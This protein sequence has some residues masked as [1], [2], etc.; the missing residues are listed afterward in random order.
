MS[1]SSSDYS[2]ESSIESNN[3][4]DRDEIVR[5]VSDFYEFIIKRTAPPEALH[6]PP[7][8]GWAEI[9]EENYAWL[10]KNEAVFDLMRH[11]PYL[12]RED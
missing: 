11:L 8:E 1:Q 3:G 4:Y 12:D 2:D 9:D 10:N 7:P 5:L 6:F